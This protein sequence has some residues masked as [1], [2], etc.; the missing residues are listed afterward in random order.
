MSQPSPRQQAI[1]DARAA[2]QQAA[3]NV[4]QLQQRLSSLQ[5]ITQS[6]RDVQTRLDAAQ[7]AFR[8]D[9]GKWAAAGAKG[10]APTAPA[11]LATLQ[12]QLAESHVQAEAAASAAASLRPEI[13]RA[14]GEVKE[15]FR[16]LGQ[17]IHELV[18]HESLPPLIRA[19]QEAALLTN[20]LREQIAALGIVAPEYR[21]LLPGLTRL[22]GAALD[23][24]SS[25]A[26][27]LVPHGAEASRAQWRAALAALFE[28]EPFALGTAPA[29]RF[30]APPRQL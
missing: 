24:V 28:G 10:L 25:A 6:P 4:A 7:A 13:E 29:S 20:S 23:A 15:S 14:Q 16:R 5:A 9:L 11:D 27:G 26:V 17:A 1:L 30:T 21:D 18:A 3:D 8:D 12:A 2:H 22:S 19:A